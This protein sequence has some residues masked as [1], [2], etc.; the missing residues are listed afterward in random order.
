MDRCP[1]CNRKLEKIKK[2]KDNIYLRCNG[3]KYEYIVKDKGREN[4]NGKN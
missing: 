4:K 3:C 1:F 2:E